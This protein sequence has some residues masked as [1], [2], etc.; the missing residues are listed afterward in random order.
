[1]AVSVTVLFTFFYFPAQQKK[2]INDALIERLDSTAE[3][4]ALS[5]GVALGL[6][7]Y[8]A[9]QES[10]YWLERDSSIVYVLLYGSDGELFASYDNADAPL[11]TTSI[12]EHNGFYE[13]NATLH[14]SIPIEFQG[15]N[16]GKLYIGYS[17]APMHQRIAHNTYTSLSIGLIILILGVGLSW[18][19]GNYI[20]K[21]IVKL[22]KAANEMAAGNHNIRIDVNTSDEVG[23][24]ARAFNIMAENIN[25]AVQSL[26]AS[27]QKYRE[28]SNELEL[29]NNMKELL[30]DIIT[31][32]LKNPAGVI[33]GIAEMMVK[34][35][36]EDELCQM[37]YNSSE[38]LFRVI[39][40]A[41]TLSKV[42]LDEKI[43]KSE[44][45]LYSIINNLLDNFKSAL[46]A[47][48]I[49]VEINIKEDQK[50]LANPIIE[51]VFKNYIS[52]ASKY[53]ADGK[54]I[55]IEAF[56][57][58]NQLIVMVKDFGATIPDKDRESVFVRNLQLGKTEGRGLGLAI[59]KRI[60][61]S[62]GGN[63]WVEPNEPTGNSFALSLPLE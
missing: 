2:Q 24:L 11:D 49:E 41:T 12:L 7:S 3:L 46:K 8:A 54:K 52:N 48:E 45:N 13:E 61:Q 6:N 56:E 38:S 58:D 35:D 50:I 31:H 32:D 16:Y 22:Q 27:E 53:A 21:P 36:P 43:E 14:G 4:I 44:L 30:L 57:K 51:E 20:S 17:L 29:S 19:G 5:T 15:D 55:I 37:V 47:N 23:D 40:N 33:Y 28:L 62:H 9:I 1:L 59:V 42:S 63:V 26:K 39:A 25:N 18:L 10:M 60:A 34:E